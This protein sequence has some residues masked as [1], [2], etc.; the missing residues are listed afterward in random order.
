MSLHPVHNL[1]MA[2]SSGSQRAK[3]SGVST[4]SFFDLKAELSKKQDEFSK[5]KKAGKKV[6]AIVGGVPR[7]DKVSYVQLSLAR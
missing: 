5:A 3:A 1:A 2:S 7:P 4:S 6:S